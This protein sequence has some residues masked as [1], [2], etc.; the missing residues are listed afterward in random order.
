[1]CLT[2][3][4]NLKKKNLTMKNSCVTSYLC[5]DRIFRR[6]YEVTFISGEQKLHRESLLISGI[7]F[8]SEK[9]TLCDSSHEF[10]FVPIELGQVSPSSLEFESRFVPIELGQVCPS[11]HLDLSVKQKSNS[12]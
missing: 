2:S 3:P 11:F 7:I 10:S 8:I 12:A 9:Q 4:M 5:L 1:M 6:N